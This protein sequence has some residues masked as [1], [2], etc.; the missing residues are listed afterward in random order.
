MS[1]MPLSSLY[2]YLSF[3]AIACHF[4]TLLSAQ[5]LHFGRKIAK[6]GFGKAFALSKSENKTEQNLITK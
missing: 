1:L 6:N 2:Y 3:F 5:N 4:V